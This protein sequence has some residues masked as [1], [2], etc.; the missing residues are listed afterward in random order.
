MPCMRLVRAEMLE[1][2]RTEFIKF[3][4]ARGLPDRVVHFRLA[5][6]NCLMPVSGVWINLL[7]SLSAN[8]KKQRIGHLP[9]P[10]GSPGGCDI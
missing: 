7:V 3:A 6:R 9:I 8:C 10:G 5:L 2:L 4:R 1:T